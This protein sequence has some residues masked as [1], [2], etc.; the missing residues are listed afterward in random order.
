MLEQSIQELTKAVEELT[1]V[2]RNQVP[3]PQPQPAKPAKAIKAAND[4]K[5]EPTKATSFSLDDVRKVLGKV[6]REEALALLNNFKAKRPSDVPQD[7]YG[8]L[9]AA[10]QQ[11]H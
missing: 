8:Q 7:Q 9:I 10:A 1:E 5:V 11:A 4:E 2:L 6:P 3:K